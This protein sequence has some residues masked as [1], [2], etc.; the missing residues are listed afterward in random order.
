MDEI[1]FNLERSGVQCSKEELKRPDL[2]LRENGSPKTLPESASGP[3][4]E[5]AVLL[6]AK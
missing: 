3:P 1:S 6:L 2:W 5:P 4:H